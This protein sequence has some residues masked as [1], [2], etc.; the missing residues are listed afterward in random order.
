MKRPKTKITQKG[1]SWV[2][3]QDPSAKEIDA[4]VHLHAIPSSV[5]KHA[6]D[7]NEVPR[8]R[9]FKRYLLVIFRVPAGKQTH[10][11]TVIIKNKTAI[12][13]TKKN[14][15]LLLAFKKNKNRFST[16]RQFLLELLGAVV[17][18]FDVSMELLVAQLDNLEAEAL[19]G[20]DI[21]HHLFGQRKQLIFVRKALLGNK[22]VI[23]KLNNQ[24]INDKT[25]TDRLYDLQTNIQ[26]QV[27]T[28]ALVQERLSEI[29]NLSL[30]TLS[31]KLNETMKT[32]TIFA[33]LFMCPTLIA[34]IYGMNFRFMPELT[35]PYGY[36]FSL[37]LMA[38][39]ITGL[40]F[41]FKKKGWW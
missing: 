33:L 17:N 6:L 15:E 41:Y 18:E 8:M 23:V 5:C 27:E 7:R 24:I 1:F 2:H 34:G 25:N 19:E 39:S 28:A 32:F 14:P 38:L 4:A 13:I 9:Q 21:R 20:H 22:E 36:A 16:P 10:P 3:L 31:N 12:T 37:G 26:Q 30:T 35:W 11:F 40:V 29:M